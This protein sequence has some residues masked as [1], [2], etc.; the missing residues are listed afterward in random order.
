MT[1]M[2]RKAKSTNNALLTQLRVENLR[3][4]ETCWAT[5]NAATR[6]QVNLVLSRQRE[7]T[8][9]QAKK[10]EESILHGMELIDFV[11]QETNKVVYLLLL[12]PFGDGTLLLGNTTQIIGHVVQHGFT[13]NE[14]NPALH[15]LLRAAWEEGH[16]RLK[17]R[18]SFEFGEPEPVL[19]SPQNS[20]KEENIDQF[21]SGLIAKDRATQSAFWKHVWKK[22]DTFCS[23][24]VRR[25]AEIDEET[26]KIL[27]LIV[28][29]GMA[30]DSL[31][32]VGL[33]ANK[34]DLKYFLG[35]ESPQAVD[36]TVMLDGKSQPI[37]CLVSDVLSIQ[38]ADK[39]HCYIELLSSPE[40]REPQARAWVL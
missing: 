35:L 31:W 21:E 12:Y 37:W 33:P 13:L 11:A 26:R 14:P 25:P 4:P 15:N 22:L 9:A 23:R 7:Q 39:R 2:K 3:H 1:Q 16:V 32:A 20:S 24:P 30:A 17:V 5:L 34:W 27:H 6:K 36:S 10:D 28:K 18:E 40:A 29:A 19:L 8:F 38:L